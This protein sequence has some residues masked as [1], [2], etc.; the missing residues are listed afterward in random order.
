[1]KKLILVCL[2]ILL[3][4]NLQA[5]TPPGGTMQIQD[6]NS[7]P[8]GK[9]CVDVS[10]NLNAAA[11]VAALRQG[12]TVDLTT[13]TNNVPI[14]VT[15]LSLVAGEALGAGSILY[16]KT[17]T[18]NGGR[19]YLYNADSTDADNDTYRFFGKAV[20]AAAGVGSAVTVR[21]FSPM[22]VMRQDSMSITYNQDEGLS[23]VASESGTG[24]EVLYSS[25]PSGEGDHVEF[26]GLILQCYDETAGTQDIV[27]F[28]GGF[29]MNVIPAAAP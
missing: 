4:F 18:T 16:M 21:L 7:C 26:T 19:M 12:W 25:A 15:H 3:A 17:D 10:G 1:M 22:W 20:A 28:F 13:L 14:L 29:D 8:D 9:A 24:Y 2:V 27:L 11:I 23:L 5:A 6:N